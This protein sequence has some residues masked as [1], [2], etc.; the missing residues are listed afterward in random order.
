MITSL[1]LTPQSQH[2]LPNSKQTWGISYRTWWNLNRI[3]NVLKAHTEVFEVPQPKVI[4][5]LWVSYHKTSSHTCLGIGKSEKERP[6]WAI[7]VSA[8][9]FFLSSGMVEC[10]GFSFP[11]E[12][13]MSLALARSCLTG[14]KVINLSDQTWLFHNL[15]FSTLSWLLCSPISTMFFRAITL[16]TKELISTSFQMGAPPGAKLGLKYWPPCW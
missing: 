11:Y 10:V 1:Q 13:A 5:E 14:Q 4:M 7:A 3:S 9:L 6:G 8:Q 16:W 15:S 12:F 2:Q